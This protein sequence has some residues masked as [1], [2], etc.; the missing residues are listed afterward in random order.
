[1]TI[2]IGRETKTHFLQTKINEQNFAKVSPSNNNYSSQQ[3]QQQQHPTTA[4]RFD[5]PVGLGSPVSSLPLWESWLVKLGV[6]QSPVQV[7]NYIRP[8][9]ETYTTVAV[10]RRPSSRWASDA[11]EVTADGGAV[12]HV[13]STQAVGP[14]RCSA[15]QSK[16]QVGGAVAGSWR[17]WW[18]SGEEGGGRRGGAGGVLMQLFGLDVLATAQRQVPAV[19]LR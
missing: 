6:S 17:L 1:M 16:G 19:P 7:N 2:F 12:P 15:P 9:L 4:G 18:G 10:S 14:S 11:A 13:S 3:Q 5:V 8:G